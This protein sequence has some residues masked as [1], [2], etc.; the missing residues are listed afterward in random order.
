[1]NRRRGSWSPVPPFRV[2]SAGLLSVHTWGSSPSRSGGVRGAAPSC[3]PGVGLAAVGHRV[4]QHVWEPGSCPGRVSNSQV[5][6]RGAEGVR[7]AVI[8]APTFQRLSEDRAATSRAGRT[9]KSQLLPGEDKP[10]PLWDL[11]TDVLFFSWPTD[12]LWLGG[13]PAFQ[14]WL[15]PG[16]SLCRH[17]RQ[18]P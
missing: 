17:L 1:M 5:G 9:P 11:C 7:S 12:H 2:E 16:S 10:C 18:G 8:L 14:A 3:S 6:P 4:T 15:T 13:S